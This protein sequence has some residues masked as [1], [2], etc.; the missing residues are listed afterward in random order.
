MKSL[1][2]VPAAVLGLAAAQSASAADMGIPIKA[3]AA[4]PGYNWSGFYIGGNFGGGWENTNF[5]SHLSNGAPDFAGSCDSSGLF[6]GGQIGFNYMVTPRVLIGGRILLG[7][8]ERLGGRRGVEWGFL[9]HWSL[10]LQY[11]HL[12]FDEV[13]REL[14]YAGFPTAFRNPQSNDSIDTFSIGVNYLFNWGVARPALA[15]RL[16]WSQSQLNASGQQPMQ[17]AGAM[18]PISETNAGSNFIAAWQATAAQV[19]ANQPAW[20]SPLVTT[21]GMLEQRFR[22]DIDDQ[23]AGNGTNTAVLGDGKGVDLIVSNSNEIQI[24]APPYDFR[25]SPT[26]NGALS[27]LGDW[28]F[29]RVKQQLASSPASGENYF[30]TV[31]L[32]VQ[33]PTGIP[34]LTSNAWT[35][36]PT[37]AFGKGW[38]DFDIQATVGGV[39]PASN[40]ATLGDQIQTNVAFQYHFM[41]VFWPEFE[42]NWTYYVDG[43]RSGLNQ[44]FLTPGLVIGRFQMADGVLFTTGLGYQIAVAPNCR[45]SPQTPAYGNARVFTSRF[46]F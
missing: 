19:R 15:H 16:D 46:N 42:V 33:A 26:G 14:R 39:L 22:F 41:K 9:P 18:T 3:L 21:T 2:L 29:M 28:A 10:R 38:G 36:L 40:V 13:G 1:Q 17:G 5:A 12:E 6:G 24:A 23:Q 4:S 45:P 31:W 37:F 43:Q 7:H 35:F 25:E 20:S 27:G 30:V 34:Q 11:L 32:Q 44:V 8:A